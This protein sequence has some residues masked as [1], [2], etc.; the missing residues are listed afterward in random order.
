MMHLLEESSSTNDDL[1]HLQSSSLDFLFAVE[2]N[3]FAFFTQTIEWDSLDEHP[4][5][6]ILPLNLVF[7][8]T[9]RF[10]QCCQVVHQTSSSIFHLLNF[11][12]R[13]I[14]VTVLL[15]QTK[16]R[17]WESS[18]ASGRPYF[19]SISESLFSKRFFSSWCCSTSRWH[20]TLY[21]RR[22]IQAIRFRFLDVRFCTCST[23][24]WLL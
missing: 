19:V 2:A 17:R 21:D 3:S 5:D 20:R 16:I 11:F 12:T 14:Q 23:V 7:F 22:S 4:S 10:P 18:I 8:L 15:R 13:L 9:Q 6:L 24:N 1:F